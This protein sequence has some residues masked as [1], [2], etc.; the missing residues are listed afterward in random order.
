MR[1]TTVME[2]EMQLMRAEEGIRI[3]PDKHGIRGH[4][5]GL[6][7]FGRNISK[8]FNLIAV[9]TSSGA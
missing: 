5:Q 7:R 2:M 8:I 3:V 4:W 6:M 1:Q 9:D